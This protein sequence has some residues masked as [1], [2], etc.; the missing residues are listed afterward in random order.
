MIL[1]KILCLLILSVINC[2]LFSQTSQSQQ[3]ANSP[4][5]YIDG[6]S[7]FNYIREQIPAVNYVRDRKD[8]DVHVLFTSQR[9][10]SSGTNYTV[11]F[12]G[13]NGFSGLNDTLRYAVNATDSDDQQRQKM[14]KALKAGLVRYIARTQASDMMDISF[15][16]G[17]VNENKLQEDDWDYWIF[18]VGANG[19]FSGE[20]NYNSMGIYS[21]LSANRT[22]EDM[23]LNFSMSN[24]YNESNFSYETSEET[25]EGSRTVTE[26][27]KNVTR[28]Q[29]ANASLIKAINGKWSWGLWGG[30]SRS[31][32]DNIDF[33]WSVSPG[34]EYNIFPYSESNIHQCRIQYRVSRKQN[35][36][37]QE[38]LY[39][40]KKE[41]LWQHSLEASFSLIEQWG[42]FSLGSDLGNYLD[43]FINMNYGIWSSA[44]L[45]LFKGFSLNFWIDYSKVG[46]QV[47][48]PL[49]DASLEGILLRR[50][51]LE[52]SFN[53]YANFGIS[54]TIGSIYNNF[55]NPRFGG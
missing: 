52:T 26:S 45:K 37:V 49:A 42:N 5:V 6:R 24:N 53:Y 51:Q 3:A 29:Y 15:T 33:S 4:N 2:A 12:I 36:Y 39:F 27:I 31:T 43:D 48:L 34:I 1:R 8:A 11:I 16:K 55:V 19:N 13:L 28:S 10:G 47:N 14:A 35:N 18:K 38:T 44:N 32:Y 21:S 7:D 17:K 50:Q 20:K 40:R 46:K 22:T 30:A 54:Y 41:E 9:T 25:E 23:K